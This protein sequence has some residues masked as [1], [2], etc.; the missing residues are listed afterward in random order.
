MHFVNTPL[1]DAYLIELNSITDERGAFCR[2]Y[3]AEIFQENFVQINLSDNTERGTLRGMHYQAEPYLEA[4]IVYCLRGEVF[5]V[6]LDLRK[7]S[8]TYKHHF[9]IHLKQSSPHAVYIPKG[10]AHG[11]LTLQ[12]NSQL[13]YLMSEFYKKGYERGYRYDDPAF[14]INWPMAPSL[15]SQKDQNHPLFKE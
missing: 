6:L 4:K 12:N 8:P 7:N 14:G 10:F 1:Q 5:D 13:L 9:G 2:L 3:C 11:F 15:I